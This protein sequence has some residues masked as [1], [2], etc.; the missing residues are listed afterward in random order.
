MSFRRELCLAAG[1]AI[2]R[3]GLFTW[4]QVL[5]LDGIPILGTD[6]GQL[7]WNMWSVER[8]VSR[9]QSPLA[10]DMVFHPLGTSLAAHVLTPAFFPV[11]AVVKAL[12]GSDDLLY[13]VIAYKVSMGLCYTVIAFAAFSF[14]T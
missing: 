12:R 10:S 1:L 7:V 5:P 2:A 13:P 14:W 6:Y 9:G 11:T 3:T 8:A 4:T